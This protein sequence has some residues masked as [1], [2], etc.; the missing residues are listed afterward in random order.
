MSESTDMVVSLST[1][2]KNIGVMSDNSWDIEYAISKCHDALCPLDQEQLNRIGEEFPA[3]ITVANMYAHH[4][5]GK[6]AFKAN[7]S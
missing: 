7:G 2:I 5:P 4:T 6:R 1:E 3:L